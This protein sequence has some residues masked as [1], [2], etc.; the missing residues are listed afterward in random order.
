MA[1]DHSLR[2]G[3]W[4]ELIER[5]RAR[6]P[7]RVLAGRSGAAYHTSTQLELRQAHA[8]ARDAVRAEFELVRDL[9][10]EFVEQWKLF[11]VS[12]LA[13]SKEEYLCRPDL[14][15][16]L[17]EEARSQ[18]AA[19]CESNADL[20]LVIG[21]GLSVTAVS[22]QVPALLPLIAEKA[23][24]RGWTLGSPFAILHCRVGI[25]N[26]VGELLNPNVVVLLI[27]ER[28][29]LSTADSLSAYMGFQTKAS[30]N[31]SNRN[32]ISN[33]HS[34]GV[35]T[36]A[37]ASRIIELAEQMMQRQTSGVTLKEE[38]PAARRLKKD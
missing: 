14:G 12:S 38:L 31:D 29:G 5:I 30:H 26:V 23:R 9:G 24:S 13:S 16:R 33:I 28:P 22:A 36:E 6:T 37:A 11:A 35:R 4:P 17:T 32:L 25:M 15:R 20:Q 7:A 10:A 1:D 19:N 34:A 8:A 21:D 3:I 27:G 2:P 18:V